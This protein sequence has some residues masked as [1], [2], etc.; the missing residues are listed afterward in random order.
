MEGSISQRTINLNEYDCF[1]FV[2]LD[3]SILEEKLYDIVKIVDIKKMQS[4]PVF[5]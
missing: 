4:I 5:K 3:G 2:N 1:N